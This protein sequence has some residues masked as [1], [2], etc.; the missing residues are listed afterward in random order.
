M[1]DHWT[2]VLS[3]RVRAAAS[4]RLPAVRYGGNVSTPLTQLEIGIDDD[5]HVYVRW[6]TSTGTVITTTFSKVALTRERFHR[7]AVTWDTT[8]GNLRLYLDG[9]LVE[10][11]VPSANQDVG[12]SITQRWFVGSSDLSGSDEFFHG[13]IDSITVYSGQKSSTWVEDCFRRMALLDA[14]TAVHW[15]VDIQD[16]DDVWQD[17]STYL[18]TDWLSSVEVSGDVDQV[19][20]TAKVSLWKSVGFAN[21][22]LFNDNEA[23]RSPV[24]DGSTTLGPDEQ[25]YGGLAA[26]L[27]TEMLRPTAG[28]RVYCARLPLGIEPTATDWQLRLQGRVGDPEWGGDSD[29]VTVEVMDDAGQLVEAWIFDEAQRFGGD[30]PELVEQ[31]M[32]DILDY[33]Y[34]RT[35][36]SVRLID[37]AVTLRVEGAPA[38]TVGPYT[39]ER[40][41]LLV[42]LQ[43]HAERMGWSLRTRWDYV[44]NAPALTLYEPDRQ[45]LHPDIV[46]TDADYR[47]IPGATVDTKTVRTVVRLRYQPDGETAGTS[48]PSIPTGTTTQVVGTRTWNAP[49]ATFTPG[50]VGDPASN[51]DP[52][53]GVAMATFQVHTEDLHSS[54]LGHYALQN[55]RPPRVMEITEKATDG[56]RTI[57]QAQAMGVAILR[58]LCQPKAMWSLDALPL[59]EIAVGDFYRMRHQSMRRGGSLHFDADQDAAVT[60]FGVGPDGGSINARGLPS[61]GVLIHLRAEGRPG[62]APAPMVSPSDWAWMVR[63]NQVIAIAGYMMQRLGLMREGRRSLVSNPA[64]NRALFGDG[65][66]PDGWYMSLGAWGTDAELVTAGSYQGSYSLALKENATAAVRMVTALSQCPELRAIQLVVATK[67]ITGAT[68]GAWQAGIQWYDDAGTLIDT[69]ILLEN[70]AGAS[71]VEVRGAGLAPAGTRH[72]RVFIQRKTTNDGVL[73][74]LADATVRNPAAFVYLTADVTSGLTAKVWE[75]VVH[76]ASLDN[77]DAAWSA[78]VFTAPASGFYAINAKATVD[79]NGVNNL[80]QVMLDHNSGTDLIYGPAS[81]YRSQSTALVVAEFHEGALWMDAGDTLEM[82]VWLDAT[83]SGYALKGGRTNTFLQ[84]QMLSSD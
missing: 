34:A 33:A 23:N 79:Y 25:T 77:A 78:G 45:R 59:P 61:G 48:V 68:G 21:L 20:E 66:P 57:A 65:S 67:K 3:L 53:A 58:D 40:K 70:E 76:D 72:M 43:E 10:A 80:T 8:D 6:Q 31:V 11:K 19:M 38:W 60:S 17:M 32:Q 47:M 12:A 63:P 81:F 36:G 56:I 39:Q 30:P 26:A 29:T 7:I 9:G 64:I 15:R 54:E 69:D 28:A 24:V 44:T 46:L 13:D 75:P 55:F 5:L 62:T 27:P 2:V 41:P 51:G 52:Q 83:P 37:P 18:G 1:V 16:A 49:P 42:A 82:N 4:G 50:V 22:G 71:W 74:G 14:Q 73:F 84:I 35:I